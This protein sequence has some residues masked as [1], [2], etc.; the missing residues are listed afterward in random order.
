MIARP[1]RAAAIGVDKPRHQRFDALFAGGS[2]AEIPTA[3]EAGGAG[4]G[5][6]YEHQ[7]AALEI[8]RSSLGGDTLINK[9]L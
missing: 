4:H 1:A 6:F 8:T 9:A 2:R 7:I 5:G 3:V